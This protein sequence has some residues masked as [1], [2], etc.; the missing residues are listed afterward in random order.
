MDT[1]TKRYAQSLWM[2]CKNDS[3]YLLYLIEDYLRVKE[4]NSR[5]S[6]AIERN[7]REVRMAF[8]I[9]HERRIAKAASK[10]ES[11]KEASDE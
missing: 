9:I 2:H 11:T 6:E 7:S 5:L 4:D 3:E 1:D 8:S 10:V